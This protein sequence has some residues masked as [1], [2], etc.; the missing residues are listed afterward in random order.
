MFTQGP[1]IT[2]R[3]VLLGLLSVVLMTLDH[4]QNLLEPVRH[5]LSAVVHPVRVAASLPLELTGLAS[6]QLTSRRDLIEENAR[7][8]NQQL[9][10]E[11]RLQRLDALEVENIRLRDLLDSAYEL[12]E[13][14][15][16]AELVAVDLD[17]YT[18]LI[19]ID[20]GTGDGVY[21]GQPVIDA[22]GI[23]GQVDEA[24]PFSATVRLISD[25][26]HA[27]PVQVNR[28][29]LR[30]VAVGNGNLHTLDLTSLPNNA[31]IRPGDLLVTSG[32]G[33]RFPAGYPVGRVSAVDTD[34]GEAFA[35][36]TVEPSGALNRIQEVLLIR[37]EQGERAALAADEGQS[38]T[39][40]AGARP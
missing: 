10:Y 8:R 12:E 24:G 26:S 19:Q 14:V 32:L 25:P 33:G 40:D 4:R 37:R 9:L 5:T 38:G 27:I 35:D 3:L 13:P 16:I 34:P 30:S 28:N 39:D 31:D 22:N 15:L 36:I 2:A 1:S 18:H 29:G 21:A 20:K 11:A 6:T 23:I 7:L 17:P